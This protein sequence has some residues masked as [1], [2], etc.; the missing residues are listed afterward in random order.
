MIA[1]IDGDEALYKAC[2]IKHTEVDWDAETAE[3]RYPKHTEA[4]DTLASLMQTVQLGSRPIELTP[5]AST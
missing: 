4:R 5:G 2:V 3:S 1:L